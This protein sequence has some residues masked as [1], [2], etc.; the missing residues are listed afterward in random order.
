MQLLNGEVDI[1]LEECQKDKVKDIKKGYISFKM[2]K[3]KIRT[4][5]KILKIINLKTGFKNEEI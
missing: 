3:I 4:I 2:E 1:N 5:K